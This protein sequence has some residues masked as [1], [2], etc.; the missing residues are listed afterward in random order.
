[1]LTDG[2]V[3]RLLDARA[4]KAKWEWRAEDQTY[5][6][7]MSLD[8]DDVYLFLSGRSLV[9]YSRIVRTTEAVFAIGLQ[10]SFASYTLHVVALS[11]STGKVLSTHSISSS[12][13]NG[14]TDFLVLS[15]SSS[16]T[17]MPHIV[18]I[19]HD[20]LKFI[21][22]SPKLSD[23]PKS[24]K[25]GVYKSILNVGLNERG[26]FVGILSDGSARALRLNADGKSGMQMLWEFSESVRYTTIVLLRYMG[27][28]I[29]SLFFFSLLHARAQS[30]ST[31][32]VWT[33]MVFRT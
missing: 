24:I 25:D 9:V 29:H 2:H 11:S 16:Q 22:L 3:V 17:S 30:Q 32:A 19:E 5:V 15:D 27:R 26:H 20:T 7:K 8:R 14:L 21:P 1:M 33:K 18:W 12:I 23:K 10:K 13:H 6:K 4:G 28:S 31:Q